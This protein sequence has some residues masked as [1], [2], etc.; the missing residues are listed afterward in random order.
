[1]RCV[2]WD[3]WVVTGVE[4]GSTTSERTRGGTGDVDSPC[5]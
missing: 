1:V 5:L 4:V 3:A 2:D